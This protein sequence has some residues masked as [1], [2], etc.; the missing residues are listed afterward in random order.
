MES[1]RDSI[2]SVFPVQDRSHSCFL[3]WDHYEFPLYVSEGCGSTEYPTEYG[4][5]VK[6][7]AMWI[8]ITDSVEIVIKAH[9]AR[10]ADKDGK[11]HVVLATQLILNNSRFVD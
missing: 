3:D 11:P 9:Q 1:Q 7:L 10:H 8:P 2:K 5:T 6:R 4:L